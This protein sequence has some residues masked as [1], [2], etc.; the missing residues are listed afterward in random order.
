MEQGTSVRS[1]KRYR[2]MSP[3]LVFSFMMRV[4]LLG[5]AMLTIP[6]SPCSVCAGAGCH[7]IPEQHPGGAGPGGRP[8]L[9]LHHQRS[10][11]QPQHH[12]DGDTAVQR[13]P[14]RT[15]NSKYPLT[16]SLAELQFCLLIKEA[17]LNRKECLAKQEPS[18][19][20]SSNPIW[21]LMTVMRQQL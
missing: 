2:Y 8:A 10:P 6:P 17:M 14:A 18:R 19:Q 1:H 20:S 7:G 5:I 11:Q 12:L 4:Y 13:Q 9:L 15:G 21:F 16:H 3:L